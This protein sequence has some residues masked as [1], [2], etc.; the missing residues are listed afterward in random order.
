M[1]D[2]L[3]GGF[4]RYSVDERWLLPHFEK[5]LYDN[6]LLARAYVDAWR[7]TDSDDLREV[8]ESTMDY[9]LADLTDRSG[10]FYS[11][12]DADSEG[13]EGTF[14]VWSPAQVRSVLSTDE[15]GLFCA[16]YDITEG[17]NFEGN[18]IPHLPRDLSTIAEEVGLSATVV[19]DRLADARSTLVEERARREPPFRDEKMLT[20]WNGMMVRAFAEAAAAFGRDDYLR[21]AAKCADFLWDHHRRD[22]RLLHSSMAGIAKGYAFLDDHAALGNACLSLYEATLDPTWYERSL[23]L[24]EEVLDRFWDDEEV[25]VFDTPHDG[26][27]LI[28]RPRD[29]MDNATPSGPSLA[30]E[31]FQRLGHLTSEGR[32]TDTARAIVQRESDALGRYA[33][34]FGRMLV[35]L[36]RLVAPPLEIAISARDETE[37]AP[38]LLEAHRVAHPSKIIGG[39]L[40]TDSP[41]DVALFD[42]RSA[43]EGRATAWVCSGYSC[44]LPVHDAA[45]LRHEVR[46][47]TG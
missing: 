19:D 46:E 21:A 27:A 18:S 12:R 34:A 16:A 35:V 33:P 22:G 41:P 24:A 11:A 14:Y 44:R 20:S 36:E 30:A 28:I 47:A 39:W 2:H 13:E 42:G 32:F 43:P 5:M 1:R 3:G 26:E 37:A 31:L 6:A 9:V 23:W 40:G 4:H 29:P 38:L 10:G 7:L 25:T 45:A 15:A 8:A 17:G